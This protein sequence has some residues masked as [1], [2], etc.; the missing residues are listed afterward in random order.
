MNAIIDSEDHVV[1]RRWMGR[2]DDKA[3]G[4]FLDG[5]FCRDLLI[6]A[7]DEAVHYIRARLREVMPI[8]SNTME[9]R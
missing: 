8:K 2:I 9:S 6:N 5:Q 3:T 4:G 1:L 7:P